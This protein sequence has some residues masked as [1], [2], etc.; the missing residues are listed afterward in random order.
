[1]SEEQS[2]YKETFDAVKSMYDYKLRREEIRRHQF[3]LILVLAGV[4]SLALFTLYT[5]DTSKPWY[6]AGSLIVIL[7]SISIYHIFPKKL[8]RPWYSLKDYEKIVKGDISVSEMYKRLTYEM[9]LLVHRQKDNFDKKERRDIITSIFLIVSIFSTLVATLLLSKWINITCSFVCIQIFFGL[10]FL[11]F[12]K[13][14]EGGIANE[15]KNFN[16]RVERRMN[17]NKNKEDIEPTNQDIM[18]K[19]NLIEIGLKKSSHFALVA[20]SF[21]IVAVAIP[22]FLDLMGT[23]DWVRGIFVVIYFSIGF[24]ILFEQI[25]KIKKLSE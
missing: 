18:A 11:Y 24:Y 25:Y 17:Q 7:Y 6:F 14:F 19:L 4:L 13:K 22:T 15:V 20:I 1:M 16:T 3:N 9:Y 23:P 12:Y 5:F 8:L 21:A 10:I 2:I